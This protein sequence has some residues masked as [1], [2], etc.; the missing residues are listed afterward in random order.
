MAR[1]GGGGHP[2]TH[3]QGVTNPKIP[4]LGMPHRVPPF[5]LRVCFRA[6]V[7]RG[8]PSE[9]LHAQVARRHRGT[10]DRNSPVST[11]PQPCQHGR[12]TAA[13]SIV[14]SRARSS[15][16]SPTGGRGLSGATLPPSS[17]LWE[18]RGGGRTPPPTTALHKTYFDLKSRTSRNMERRG[19]DHPPPIHQDVGAALDPPIHHPQGFGHSPTHSPGLREPSS[20][21]DLT[22]VQPTGGQTSPADPLWRKDSRLGKH[23]WSRKGQWSCAGFGFWIFYL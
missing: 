8:V 10:I 13:P 15:A 5:R 21:K 1:G 7:P 18:G 19:S 9:V 14:S 6:A 4:S 3:F 22:G 12:R 17:G 11:P 16:S 23:L 20:F 2:P